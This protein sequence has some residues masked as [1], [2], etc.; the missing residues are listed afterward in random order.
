MC[1]RGSRYSNEMSNIRQ[2]GLATV[3]NENR[4]L[5]FELQSNQTYFI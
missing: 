4:A 2:I 5:K 3:V 1:R